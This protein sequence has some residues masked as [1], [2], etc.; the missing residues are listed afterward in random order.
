[1][2]RGTTDTGLSLPCLACGTR[3]RVE[4]IRI[5]NRSV[6]LAYHDVPGTHGESCKANPLRPLPENVRIVKGNL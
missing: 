2:K 4:E 1:M 3:T 6:R 5:Q